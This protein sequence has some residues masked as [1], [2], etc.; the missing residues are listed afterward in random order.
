MRH[1]LREIL[2][3]LTLLPVLVSSLS[4]P[5][6]GQ[7]GGYELPPQE[8]VDII[9]AEPPPSL[10]LSPDSKSMLLASRQ[11]MPN[12]QGS[13]ATHAAVG[14]TE[15]RS[16]ANSSFRTSFYTGLS[17]R[18]RDDT[19]SVTPIP[20]PPATKIA[21]TSWCHDSQ[22]IAIVVVTDSGQELWIV[23]AIHRNRPNAS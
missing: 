9:D 20:L 23:Q 3:L 5:L 7:T 16:F 18:T 19:E 21:S 17:L 13:L 14:W 8:V 4:A 10:R 22:R 2:A 12:I 1:C 6:A 11:A 15:T